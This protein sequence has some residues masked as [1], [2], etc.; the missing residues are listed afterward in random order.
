MAA[1]LRRANVRL[2][3]SPWE[4]LCVGGT[5]PLALLPRLAATMALLMSWS[6]ETNK[7]CTKDT[8][9]MK[10]VNRGD[11]DVGGGGGVAS[12]VAVLTVG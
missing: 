5:V 4:S 10:V 11:D 1:V 12:A 7:L 8:S 9:R 6:T 2:L 3:S